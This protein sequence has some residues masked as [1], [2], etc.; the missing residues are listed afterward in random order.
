MRDYR[1]NVEVFS[2]KID[3]YSEA[4]DLTAYQPRQLGQKVTAFEQKL[5]ELWI[6]DE[7]QHDFRKERQV[8]RRV[9][10]PVNIP[11]ERERSTSNRNLPEIQTRPTKTKPTDGQG[12]FRNLFP[13]NEDS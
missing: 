6:E 8:P 11:Q 2:H 12:A 13:D 3:Q 10:N 9:N 4:M 7:E 5:K 1:R